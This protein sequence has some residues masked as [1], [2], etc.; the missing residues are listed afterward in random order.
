MKHIRVDIPEL[1][2]ALTEDGEAVIEIAGLK[3]LVTRFRF[4]DPPGDV[5]EVPDD[6]VEIV[7]EA[8][9]ADDRDV[10]NSEEAKAFLAQRREERARRRMASDGR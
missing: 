9:R 10:V 5:Y 1:A 6:E 4:E 7:R 2:S 8:Q 3:C